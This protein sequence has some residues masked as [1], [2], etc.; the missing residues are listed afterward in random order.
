MG[1]MRWQEAAEGSV[2]GALGLA[3]L[4]ALRAKRHASAIA[5]GETRR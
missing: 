1:V 4:T 3:L 2:P 5:E